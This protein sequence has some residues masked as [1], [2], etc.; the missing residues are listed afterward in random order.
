MAVLAMRTLLTNVIIKYTFVS[1]RFSSPVS[2][3]G[4]AIP[5]HAWTGPE[6]SRRF[7]HPDFKMK[8][9]RLSVLRTGRLYPPQEIFLIL[10]FVRS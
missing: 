5:L 10:I 6:G 2:K 4:K 8:V 7:R 1:F 3:K 9:V